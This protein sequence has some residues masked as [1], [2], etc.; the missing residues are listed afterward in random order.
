M[1]DEQKRWRAAA[2]LLQR[3]DR[4]SENR[5]AAMG[6]KPWEVRSG[7]RDAYLSRYTI[8]PERDV[9]TA[10]NLSEIDCDVI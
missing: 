9:A 8:A 3:W 6:N 7:E 5:A 10:T 4:S 2:S 1:H